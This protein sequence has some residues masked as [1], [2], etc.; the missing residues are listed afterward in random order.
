MGHQHPLYQRWYSMIKRVR[1]STQRGFE[2]YGGRGITVDHRWLGYPDGFARFLADMGPCP[3]G[4][5][6]ERIDN[7]GPYS[8]ENCRWAH[9]REQVS[10]KRSHGWNKLTKDDATAIRNDMRRHGQ[11][12]Q[13]Y[14]VTRSMISNIKRGESF[15]V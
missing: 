9:P 10:N 1:K 4:Y 3:S 7:D 2:N 15:H 11:I 5:W 6:I 14:G 13:D 12:A 8:P